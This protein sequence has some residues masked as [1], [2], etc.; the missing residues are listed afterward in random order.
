MLPSYKSLETCRKKEAQQLN[1]PKLSGLKLNRF[2]ADVLEHHAAL[3]LFLSQASLLDS[4]GL[5]RLP[6]SDQLLQVA[7]LQEKWRIGFLLFATQAVLFLS[8]NSV[9]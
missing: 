3:F 1:F 2:S 9:R 5:L 7:I 8:A 6:F 4:A